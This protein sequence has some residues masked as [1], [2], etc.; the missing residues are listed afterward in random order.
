MGQSVL[1]PSSELLTLFVSF[2]DV[3]KGWAYTTIKSAMSA[4]SY[5]L[6][7]A[8][9]PNP[10]TSFA[11]SCIL[12]GLR[13][14]SGLIQD[15][16]LP[17]L[18]DTLHGMLDTIV[19]DGSLNKSDR[20]LFSAITSTAFHGFFRIGNLTFSRADAS[21]NIVQLSNV[22]VEPGPEG[23]QIILDISKFKHSKGRERVVISRE[24]SHCPV[25]LLL[26]YL[27]SR[28]P[29]PGPLFRRD[30]KPVTRYLFDSIFQKT[31]LAMGL[32]NRRYKPHSL[33]IG[34]ASQAALDGHTTSQI[35]ARGRW[36][37]DAF[38]KYIRI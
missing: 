14:Q 9:L 13:K 22:H 26:T 24:P 3:H 17:I 15:S 19:S 8:A 21:S 37:S 5:I 16:R 10:T 29:E 25:V 28:G 31:V 32:D 33:R 7:A 20:L 38:T 23:V 12:N 30:G 36:H 34:A 4:I 35:R 1:P 6:Q 11:V 27:Q 2:L 18:R